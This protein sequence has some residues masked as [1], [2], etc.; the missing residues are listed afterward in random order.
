ML[1]GMSLIQEVKYTKSSFHHKS[2]F[3]VL[4]FILELIGLGKYLHFFV[5]IYFI[6]KVLEYTT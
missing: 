6:P 3:V 1:Q 2:N 4:R 5:E